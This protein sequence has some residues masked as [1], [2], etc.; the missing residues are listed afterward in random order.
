MSKPKKPRILY[1]CNGDYCSDADCVA[2]GFIN[3]SNECCHC[4]TVKYA[5]NGPI[6][7]PIDFLKRFKI[8]FYPLFYIEERR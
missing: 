2:K 3:T 8:H 6:K 1:L 4:T 7:G 5:K